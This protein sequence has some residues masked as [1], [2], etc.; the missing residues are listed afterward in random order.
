MFS[1]I[2]FLSDRE[3]KMRFKGSLC[4]V[5]MLADSAVADK[6]IEAEPLNN[7]YELFSIFIVDHSLVS[8]HTYHNHNFISPYSPE[9]NPGSE[10][11]G[12]M[13]SKN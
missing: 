11:R 7:F 2:S 1:N 4:C 8:D 6:V 3:E 13:A 5:V 12:E 10:S 9:Y